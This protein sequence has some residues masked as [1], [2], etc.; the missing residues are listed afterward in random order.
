[1]HGGGDGGGDGR[2]RRAACD[3]A[4]RGNLGATDHL[5][6]DWSCESLE[7]TAQGA[8]RARGPRRARVDRC[9]PGCPNTRS[10][11]AGRRA[12]AGS[13]TKDTSLDQPR[14]RGLVSRPMLGAQLPLVSVL[15]FVA[16]LVAIA[17]APLVASH[18]WH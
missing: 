13:W 5:R 2:A 11:T 12:V 3:A 15:P 4:R 1:A 9:A 6:L 10:G 14:N 8:A 7:G 16:L 18:W 17:L